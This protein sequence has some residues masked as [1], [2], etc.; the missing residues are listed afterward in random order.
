[1]T[2]ASA[3]RESNAIEVA[4]VKAGHEV[5]ILQTRVECLE[6]A[7]NKAEQREERSVANNKDVQGMHHQQMKEIRKELCAEVEALKEKKNHLQEKLSRSEFKVKARTEE[8]DELTSKLTCNL[9]E[10]EDLKSRLAE[11]NTLHDEAVLR[12]KSVEKTLRQAESEK[13]AAKKEAQ[14]NKLAL[15]EARG[16]HMKSLA[17]LEASLISAVRAS[18]CQDKPKIG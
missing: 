15:D 14:A 10:C 16:M 12:R 2:S 8:V 1:M 13:E 6:A 3:E 7:L 17:N 4:R 9:A 11:A 18:F 5:L